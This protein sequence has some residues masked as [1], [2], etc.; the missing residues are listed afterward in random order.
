MLIKYVSLEI[1]LR[2]RRHISKHTYGSMFR[3]IGGVKRQ[4]D[5][6]IRIYKA[7]AVNLVKVLNFS[8]T[9]IQQCVDMRGTFTRVS[10]G[11]YA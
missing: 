6:R 8:F 9:V 10:C 4:M 11:V 3:K 1:T 5:L 2:S 7:F